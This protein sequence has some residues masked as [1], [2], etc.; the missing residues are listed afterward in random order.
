[1]PI[2]RKYGWA[3]DLPDQRDHLYSA[4]QPVL[5]KMPPKKDLRSG[6][7]P[8]YDQ[9]QL[10]SC[11]A[12]A[13]SGAI[14]FEQKKQKVK[15]FVPSR[16]F[17]YYN[18]RDMEGTVNSD[19]GAQIRDGVKS[20]ANLGVCPEIEWPY[21]INKFANKP[22]PKCYT[23]ATK[24][25]AV[26]YQRLDSSNL[27]QLKG[28]IASGFPFVFGFTVYDAF[29]SPE[30]AKTGVLNMPGPKEKVQGGH[31]VLAVGYDD[32]TQ[33]F[34]VRNSWGKD[35]GIKG[36]FTIPYAYLT[37]SNLADDFWTIRIL[38]AA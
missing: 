11:T 29:E 21:D 37:T 3:P 7:P 5:A 18:E 26:G 14:Q 17:I 9:G 8:V 24:C 23:D 4:P 12:N 34:A 10:G 38:K 31:A 6:C 32:A 25:Q 28:C 16:L 19:A 13:I 36:Y 15:I 20:V 27:N 2:N 1:M 33:R 30:V 22:T 35:W